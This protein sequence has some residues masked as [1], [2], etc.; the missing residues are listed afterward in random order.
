ML[1]IHEKKETQPVSTLRV[2]TEKVQLQDFPYD[3]ST[4]SVFIPSPTH[5]VWTNYSS[6]SPPSSLSP[7]PYPI[8][9]EKYF[10]WDSEFITKSN[11]KTIAGESASYQKS[12]TA[13]DFPRYLTDSIIE[14]Y[15]S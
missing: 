14:E 5:S 10:K 13:L 6:H 9:Y 15:I 4:L 2:E 12:L 11:A 8:N 7:S 1:T 3:F